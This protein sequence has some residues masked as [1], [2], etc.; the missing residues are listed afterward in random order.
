MSLEPF[1]RSPEN[2]LSNRSAMRM[3]R[4]LA[5][6]WSL[7]EQRRPLDPLTVKQGKVR[8]TRN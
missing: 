7:M 2:N 5:E 4:D 8:Q 6:F 3:T 1:S